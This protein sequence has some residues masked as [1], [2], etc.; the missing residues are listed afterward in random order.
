MQT[1]WCPCCFRFLLYPHQKQLWLASPSP[2][3]PVASES[4]R[5]VTQLRNY[6]TQKLSEVQQQREAKNETS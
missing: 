1:N 6:F 5:K 4:T 3:S 2:R